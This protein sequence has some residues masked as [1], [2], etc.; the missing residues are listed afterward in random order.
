MHVASVAKLLDLIVGSVNDRGLN[1]TL[2]VIDILIQ[3]FH[4]E[5]PQLI[6]STLQASVTLCLKFLVIC[7]SGGDDHDPS[8]TAVKAS[9]A[10]ILARILVMNTNFP[11]QLTS[12]PPLSL[13]MQQAG[14]PVD[15]NILLCLVDIWLDRVS[16]AFSHCGMVDNVSSTYKKTFGLALSIILT[17][18][19]PRAPDELDQ[20]LRSA[21][22]FDYVQFGDH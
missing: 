10:A 16:G 15:E 12:D 6:S 14:A 3:C 13:L 19:L 9:S 18:R 2:P 8:K 1:S 11:A 5:V 4:V 7:F 20:I 21:F 17:L 22:N